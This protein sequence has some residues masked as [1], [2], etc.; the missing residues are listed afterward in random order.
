MQQT[1]KVSVKLQQ[2]YVTGNICYYIY[3]LFRAIWLQCGWNLLLRE[4][5]H[6]AYRMERRP[7]FADV[8]YKK[9]H[10]NKSCL[11]NIQWNKSTSRTIWNFRE[12]FPHCRLKTVLPSSCYRDPIRPDF[13]RTVPVLL[14]LQ[15]SVPMS[16][17]ILF[18]TPNVP[19]FISKS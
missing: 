19:V 10:C 15:I 16:R 18:G 17:Q 5:R 6:S 1:L 13:P 8:V 14:V 7:F 3:I 9:N 4:L 11:I 12:T 2:T